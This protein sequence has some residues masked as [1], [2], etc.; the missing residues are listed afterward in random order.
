MDFQV[1][2]CMPIPFYLQGTIS[3]FQHVFF[4]LQEWM[5]GKARFTSPFAMCYCLTFISSEEVL[6][7]QRL[8]ACL[9]E[10]QLLWRTFLGVSALYEQIIVCSVIVSGVFLLLVYMVVHILYASSSKGDKVAIIGRLSKLPTMKLTHFIFYEIKRMRERMEI[11]IYDL[12]NL[13]MPF[14][15]VVAYQWPWLRSRWWLEERKERKRVDLFHRSVWLLWHSMLEKRHTW[16]VYLEDWASWFS[17][18]AKQY[19]TKHP[20]I[21]LQ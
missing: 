14:F 8:V 17:N 16:I 20:V 19:G 9:G 11:F 4:K 12:S 13:T 7:A 3:I 5:S 18:R 10:L 21:S 1:D 2:L 15:V 6:V